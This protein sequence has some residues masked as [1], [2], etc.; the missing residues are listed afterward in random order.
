MMT[1]KLSEKSQE[2]N[3]AELKIIEKD[4]SK[5]AAEAD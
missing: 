2:V 3:A 4:D 5:A 1:A